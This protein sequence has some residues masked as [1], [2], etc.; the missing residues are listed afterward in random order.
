MVGSWCM[1]HAS[2]HWGRK[3]WE[4]GYNLLKASSATSLYRRS[5]HFLNQYTVIWG[6]LLYFA[7]VDTIR[8]SNGLRTRGVWAPWS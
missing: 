4:E 3:T 8:L 7:G 1:S 2:C 5:R 6:G